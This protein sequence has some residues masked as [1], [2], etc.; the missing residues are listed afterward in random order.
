MK[1]LLEFIG[2]Y[3]YW[4]VFALLEIVS[5]NMLLRWANYQRSLWYSAV[6]EMNG[7]VREKEANIL[8]YIALAD[9]NAELTEYN[10]TLQ[11]RVDLLTRELQ[12][13]THD[14]TYAERT[15]MSA[16]ATNARLIR[17]SIID[18]SIS[19]RDNLLVINRGSDDGVEDEMGVVCGTGVVGIVYSCS[20]HYSVVMP[21]LHSKSSISCRLRGADYFGYLHW[22]GG[23]PL[24]AVVDD[25]PLHAHVKRGDIVETSGYSAIFPA[26]LFVGRVD[27]VVNSADGLSQT[28]RVRLGVDFGRLRDVCVVASEKIQI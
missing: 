2:R 23:D 21:V 5:V 28:L 1:S 14:S 18:A 7:W 22:E 17:A 19:R 27:D 3:Y 10:V 11:Q 16:A 20:A 4:A 24:T 6:T 12:A 9:R 15:I 8:Q 26:G 25:I 13:L